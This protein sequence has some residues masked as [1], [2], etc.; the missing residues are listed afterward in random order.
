MISRRAFLSGAAA[1]LGALGLRLPAP[2]L[3]PVLV[4]PI[5]GVSLTALT[6]R[7]FVPKAVEQIYQRS[8]MFDA[9]IANG[10]VS[11]GGRVVMPMTY[12]VVDH[13]A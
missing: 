2:A 5:D 1:F 7:Y 9:I 3:P 10:R 4:S 11:G 8:P 13:G 6:K 12:T